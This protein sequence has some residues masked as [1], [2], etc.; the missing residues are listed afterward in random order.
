M[1]KFGKGIEYNDKL[2]PL[3]LPVAGFILISTLLREYPAIFVPVV[4]HCPHRESLPIDL[5][6]IGV[7]ATLD[8]KVVPCALRLGV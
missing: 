3:G 2:K 1:R 7:S 6:P 4:N 8:R 5:F